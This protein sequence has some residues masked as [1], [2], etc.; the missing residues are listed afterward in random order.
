MSRI[1]NVW[2]HDSEGNLILVDADGR[3][4]V[5]VGDET[6][7]EWLL[8]NGGMPINL[9]DGDGLQW[10]QDANGG[11][12][13][14][15]IITDSTGDEVTLEPDN[16]VPVTTT[17]VL[18]DAYQNLDPQ[19]TLPVQ[20]SDGTR[21]TTLEPDGSV[22]VTKQDAHTEI[23]D[24]HISRLID[25]VTLLV[26]LNI[27][28]TDVDIETTGA[29]PVIGDTLCLKDVD[30]TAF[31]QGE[32]VTVTP[33][34]GNQYQLGIDT[35][36][37]F[38]FSTAD[39]CSIRSIDLAVDGSVTPVRFVVSPSGLAS[40]TEWDLTRF[41]PVINGTQTMDDG[42]FGDI[43]ALTNGVV[44]RTENGTTKNIFNAKTNGEFAEHCF[45]RQYAARAP[46]GQ[47]SV[48]IRRSTNGDDKNGVVMRLASD[49]NDNF[50]CIV[51]DDLTGL[52]SFKVVAQGHVVQ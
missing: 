38:A 29:T 30:G 45:D 47:T 50:V 17:N 19:F 14:N 24:L 23:V 27:D 5:S 51:Q 35:P 33:L 16:S 11:M 48:A 2:I 22:P 28:D 31:Y 34:G 12:P 44:F 41:L 18:A 8:N 21:Q 4:E 26:A 37:D 43:S 9:H 32:V 6:G 7:A 1:R 49:G 46:A 52:V 15:S 36:M 20:I 13:V 25:T 10:T 42:L 39:G 3:I 40:G